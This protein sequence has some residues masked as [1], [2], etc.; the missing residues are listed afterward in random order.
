MTNPCI[1]PNSFDVTA[2]AISPK[3]HWQ[4]QHRATAVGGGA[5][6]TPANNSAGTTLF[7]VQVQWT[8]NTPITQNVYALMTQGPVRYVIDGMKHLVIR[9]Q[10]GTSSGASPADPTLTEESRVRGYPDFG[11]ALNG[12]VT[13]AVYAQLED[14]QPTNSVPIGD[15]IA[16]PAGQ[17]MK[18]RVQVSWLT[19][20][21]GV[22]WASQWG[23][24]AT[25]RIGKVGPVQ[26]DLFST[27]VIP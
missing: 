15:L 2:G 7:T 16:L 24:P 13:I 17:T 12:G 1:D 5:V 27:P 20:A 25:I 26:I 21:W 3:R 9:Y 6:F 11:T 19:S 4:F 8:N 18:A 23:D 22:D 10:W 14:R